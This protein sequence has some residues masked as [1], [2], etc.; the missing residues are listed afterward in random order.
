[1]IEGANVP[2][3]LYYRDGNWYDEDGN[4]YKVVAWMPLPEPYKGGT[5]E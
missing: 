2:T 4:Y 3:C 5:D 1:M